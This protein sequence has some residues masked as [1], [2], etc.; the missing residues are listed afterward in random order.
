VDRNRSHQQTERDLVAERAA[1][2][3]RT[4]ER[5]EAAL[6]GLAAA[7]AAWAGRRTPGALDRRRRALAEAGERLW[8]LVVQREALGLYRHD[9][10][11][12]ALRVPPEVRRAMGPVRRG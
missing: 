10:L 2:L 8:F 9:E 4:T 5:L 1:A 12:Q 7:D 11:F 6:E 3:A